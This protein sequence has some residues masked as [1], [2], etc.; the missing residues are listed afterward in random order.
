M[1]DFCNSKNKLAHKLKQLATMVHP[2]V[3][4]RRPTLHYAKEEDEYS[5]E[6]EVVN[7]F[8]GRSVVTQIIN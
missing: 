8:V 4:R 1:I 2:N 3:H 6:D 7:S 5:V